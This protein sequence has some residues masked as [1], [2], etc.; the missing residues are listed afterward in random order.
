MCHIYASLYVHTNPAIY[1][2]F[3]HCGPSICRQQSLHSKVYKT[4]LLEHFLPHCTSFS[5][6]SRHRQLF[7][8]LP[9]LLFGPLGAINKQKLHLKKRTDQKCLWTEW[10]KWDLPAQWASLSAYWPSPLIC[11][12]ANGSPY[13]WMG[14][15]TEEMMD[16]KFKQKFFAPR[17]SYTVIIKGL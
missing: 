7:Y 11:R 6:F 2:S 5:T 15:I 9:D 13:P 8:A 12:S 10:R 1:F 17:Y 3:L 16:K 4:E 14:Y